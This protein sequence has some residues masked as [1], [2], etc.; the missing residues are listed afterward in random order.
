MP[1]ILALPLVA[2]FG[3]EFPQQYLAHFLGAA[4]AIL[5]LKLS[6][7]IKNNF[8]VAIWSCLVISLGS[9]IWFLSSVGSVW[10]LGQISAAFFLTAALVESLSKKRAWLVGILFGAA[11]LSRVHTILSLPIF[12]YLLQDEFK[13][14]KNLILFCSFTFIFVA[15]NM[16][17]NFTRFGVPY[18]KGYFLIPGTA[19]EP[20]FAKG[21][22]HPS[23][24]I[25][26][27]KVAFLALPKFL[28]GPP[29][30]Q[31]SWAGM[32]IW[33]TTPAFIYALFAPLRQRIV[34]LSWLAILLI[35]L[36]V[37]MHGGTG[38]AQ[39][40]YRFA[41]D[42]YPFLMLLT[43]K[44]VER[45]GLHWY[46]WLLFFLGFLVNLWGVVWINKFNWVSF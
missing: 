2:L 20:W 8:K 5:T 32:S 29:Y 33:L 31:P 42:F 10:Y 46:S 7:L 18:D 25:E 30:I 34:Q 22:V 38:F 12:I 23:Y 39:F 21:I 3:P 17:Y 37:G 41:V 44:G 15:F 4:I 16:W 43:I 24:I 1:A 36:V 35:F 28:D 14:R 9:I 27:L 13:N 6:Y 11:Y 45:T 19:N 26:D 40:G